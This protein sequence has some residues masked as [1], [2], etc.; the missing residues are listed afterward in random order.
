VEISFPADGDGF[1][2]QEC[3]SC[4]LRFKVVFGEGSEQPLSGCPYCGFEGRDCWWTQAQADY[5]SAVATNVVLGPELS[6][7]ERSLKDASDGLLKIDLKS[8]ASTVPRLQ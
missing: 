4:K 5:I 3:P 7:F 2:S 8:N 1:L 6:K